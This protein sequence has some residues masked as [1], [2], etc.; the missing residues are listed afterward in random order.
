MIP[1]LSVKADI[2]PIQNLH[3]YDKPWSGGAGKNKL[4]D[5]KKCISG[6]AVYVGFESY[7][8]ATSVSC[9]LSA[10]TYTFSI[11]TVDGTS[12]TALYIAEKG[13]SE[14]FAYKYGDKSVS[15]T[16]SETTEIR[17]WAYKVGYTDIG[18]SAIKW[19][20]IELGSTATSWTP[21]SNICPIYGHTEEVV[22]V[23]GVNLIDQSAMS[24][25]NSNLYIG[26]T[27]PNAG[28]D[29]SFILPAGTYTLSTSESQ[30]GLYATSKTGNIATAHNKTKLTFTLTEHTPIKLML[31]K[32]GVN[33]T[34]W[35]TIN[36]QLELNNDASS[37]H[38]YQG[39]T[40]TTSLGRT[41]YGGTID[42]V[43]GELVVDRAYVDLSQQ[44][45]LYQSAWASWYTDYFADMKGT[46]TGAE[47]PNFVSDRFEAIATNYGL[48]P[49]DLI[50]ITSTTRGS[51]GCRIVVKN[52]STTE[53]PTGQ[54]VYELATPTTIQ[55]TPQEIDSFKGANNIWAS[56]GEI[57]VE[58]RA[59]I[60]LYIEKKLS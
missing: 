41:V 26:G 37:Y 43:S 16:I 36:V 44:S 15:F 2:E 1:A 7:D 42:V 57:E 27:A 49:Q 54:L 25:T 4:D 6:N 50:G 23:C 28:A 24:K 47:I 40:H 60:G 39:D 9:V 29:G 51:L 18:T 5:S 17:A 20:Q 14:S 59:D 35:D 55:L 52:G 21:Y 48:T 33:S 53:S 38:A 11:D 32:S 31:Y 46:N 22:N 56:T 34:Y 12:P 10:G 30:N 58:Y 3:G 19:A 45:W 13:E 8:L